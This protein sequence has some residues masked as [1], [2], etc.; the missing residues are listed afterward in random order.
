MSIPMAADVSV[1]MPV[2]NGAKTV[3]RALDS[4]FAQSVAPCEVIAVDDVSTDDTRAV[5]DA[6]A[7]RGLTVLRADRNGGAGAARNRGAAAARGTYLAFIDADDQ[8]HPN[9]L[10]LQLA[11]LADAGPTV[12]ASCTGY[13]LVTP[14]RNEEIRYIDMPAEIGIEELA[15]GC[16][17]SP[18]STLLVSRACFAM[19][20]PFDPTLRRYEDWDWLLRYARGYRLRLERAALATVFDDR[21]GHASALLSLRGI[22]RKHRASRTFPSATSRLKFESHLLLEKGAICHRAGRHLEAVLWTAASLA[23]YPSRLARTWASVNR[24]FGDFTF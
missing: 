4:V 12:Q 9:K 20:G 3:E 16:A 18:G 2:Y 13:R 11:G 8:W 19:V 10:E 7:P 23:V 24:A 14:L 1:I 15:G 6:Y 22:A 17:V 5:L 21:T